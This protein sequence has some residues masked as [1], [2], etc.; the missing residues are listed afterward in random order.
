MLNKNYLFLFLSIFIGFIISLFYCKEFSNNFLLLFLVISICLYILFYLLGNEKETYS[1][2]NSNSSPYIIEGNK[3]NY[4]NK[5]PVVE[6]DDLNKLPAVEEDHHNKLTISEEDYHNK[7]IIPEEEY[8][9]KL[10]IPEEE[11]SF[12]KK[13][14]K[15]TQPDI[16][17]FVMNTPVPTTQ[18]LNINISYNSQNN[19]NELINNK[20]LMEG[21]EIKNKNINKDIDKDIDK[22]L[23]N[24]QCLKEDNS[25]IY[26]NSDWLYGKNAWTKD[27]DYYIPTDC[28]NMVKE[29]PQTLNELINSKKYRDNNKTPSP[30]MINTP[31]TEYKSGDSDPEPFNL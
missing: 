12:H 28:K 14:E 11:H 18:P 9:N 4:N 30:L 3:L 25:R 19:V 6:E 22:N 2:Y 17:K 20:E 27:P 15:N 24:Y 29:I 23:G 16:N 21:K 7:L 13:E 5:L 10:I 8:H 31:W 26:N 1:N